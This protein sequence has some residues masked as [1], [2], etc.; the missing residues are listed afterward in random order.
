VRLL[1]EPQVN[2]VFAELPPEVAA[3]LRDRGWHFYNF[4]AVNGCRFMCSWDTQ[5]AD[6][7]NFLADL[8]EVSSGRV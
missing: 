6:V 8:K 5:E 1:V 2:A 4:I 7:Q 3:A